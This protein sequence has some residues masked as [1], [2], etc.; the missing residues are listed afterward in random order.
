MFTL[1]IKTDGSAFCDP[2]TGEKDKSFEML[3]LARILKETSDYLFENAMISRRNVEFK[4]LFD[5]NG[6]K[7]GEIRL[8]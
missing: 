2:S 6:N 1:K 3:E 5:I 8:K 4:A 7:V